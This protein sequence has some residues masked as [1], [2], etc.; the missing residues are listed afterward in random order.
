MLRISYTCFYKADIMKPNRYHSSYHKTFCA[1]IIIILLSSLH[2]RAQQPSKL[3]A[4]VGIVNPI[5]SLSSGTITPNF[6]DSYQVGMPT[7]IN[8]LREGHLGFS[9]EMVPYIKVASGNS[10][11]SNFLFHPGVLFP[12]GKEFTFIARAAFETSGRYGLTPVLSKVITHGQA[13]KLFLATPFP[14][15][16]GNEQKI[17]IAA[18]FQFGYIF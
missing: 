2:L 12:I 7:G 11:M 10:K 8:I 13:G 9:L 14:V 15:R 3:V 18:A 17:S 5:V 1:A 4:Y 16:F 6:K